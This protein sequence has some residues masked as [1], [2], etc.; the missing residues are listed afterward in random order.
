MSES[1]TKEALEK[2][3]SSPDPAVRMAATR[4]YKLRKELSDLDGF[5]SFYVQAY[6]EAKTA[7]VIKQ[8]RPIAQTRASSTRSGMDAFIHRVCD[9][10]VKNGKP[11]KIGRLYET[12][13]ESYT[14]EDK[15]SLDTFRI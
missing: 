11:I 10:L 1:D 4:Y 12:F 14:D 7:P 8:A 15:L 13:Y 2:A 6:S 3:A 5:F 9:L